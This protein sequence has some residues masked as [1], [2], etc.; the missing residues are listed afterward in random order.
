[1]MK[2][3]RENLKVAKQ[4]SFLDSFF[5]GSAG[6]GYNEAPALSI[7]PFLYL[8]HPNLSAYVP[9]IATSCFCLLLYRIGQIPDP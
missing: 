5:H 7:L 8:R 3:T 6:S 1:M 2:S 9:R 4:M